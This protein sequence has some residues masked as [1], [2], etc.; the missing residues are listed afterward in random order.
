MVTW[1]HWLSHLKWSAKH[2]CLSNSFVSCSAQNRIVDVIRISFRGITDCLVSVDWKYVV[3]GL[4]RYF[5]KR[6]GKYKQR[7]EGKGI[8]SGLNQR[9]ILH[10]LYIVL[11][12]LGK[13]LQEKWIRIIFY[14]SL[15]IA[16]ATEVLF[17]IVY[18][19]WRVCRYAYTR[20]CYKI[21][22]TFEWNNKEFLWTTLP[23][24]TWITVL[25]LS[26]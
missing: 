6:K 15:L 16:A 17:R 4:F 7:E 25:T 23:C 13:K 12:L 19:Y 14:T 10:L 9:E 22:R 21:M 18:S 24:E 11:G 26:K 2:L 3:D 20:I 5:P 1:V 8:E